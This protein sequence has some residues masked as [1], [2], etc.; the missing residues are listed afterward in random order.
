MRI[1]LLRRLKD[2][3]IYLNIKKASLPEQISQEFQR[4]QGPNHT[5]SYRAAKE[6]MKKHGVPEDEI[7]PHSRCKANRYC[8]HAWAPCELDITDEWC[9]VSELLRTDG[10]ISKNQREVKLVSVDKGLA[11]KFTSI[12]SKLGIQ[13]IRTEENK[14]D[15]RVRILDKTFAVILTEAFNIKPGN[16]SLTTTIP[17]W[18]RHLSKEQ[19]KH[20]LQGAFDGDGSVQYDKKART[21]RIRLN[22]GSEN[23]AKDV[24][25]WL[26]KLGI[27]SITFPDPRRKGR[28]FYLQISKKEDIGIFHERVK[29][30]HKKRKE[31]LATLIKGYKRDGPGRRKE[32]ILAF[33]RRHPK[34]TCTAI[35][36]AMKLSQSTTS[37]HL[38]ALEKEGKIKKEKL[39]QK[40]LITA[41]HHARPR[42]P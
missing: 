31:G 8:N 32:T 41:A 42:A 3:D 30:N 28:L 17:K 21:R 5:L 14:H 22:T 25:S 23:Y 37:T 11:E 33:I 15:Y 29:L 24:K 26:D 27:R 12:A 6:V 2:H 9:Y 36:K 1:N 16:K 35:S 39:Q 38:K 18:M 13:N 20:C 7:I 34:T 10:H 4:L 19:V 40:K